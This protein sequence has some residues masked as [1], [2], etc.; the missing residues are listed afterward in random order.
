M[1]R[2]YQKENNHQE[3]L[4]PKIIKDNSFI[5]L[6]VGHRMQ[7]IFTDDI[8][9]IEGMKDYLR[10]CTAGEKIMTLMNFAGIEEILP[11]EKFV[12]VHRSFIVSIEKIDHIE[13]NRIKILDQ[14]IPIGDSYSE[15][16]FNKIKGL[17]K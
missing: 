15:Y 6:K 8:Y 11:Y 1:L 14:Y 10:I 12:R 5:F 9:Y 13:R 4:E 7:K 16:F 2:L 17:S 3:A